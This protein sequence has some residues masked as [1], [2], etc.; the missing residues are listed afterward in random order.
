MRKKWENTFM[1]ELQQLQEKIIKFRDERDWAQFH[2]PKELAI[3]LA[4]ETAELMENF[5]WAKGATKEYQDAKRQDIAD[6]LA[7][8]MIYLL[9]F[10]HALDIN[11]SD[12]IIRKIERSAAKYPVEKSFG[13]DTKHTD[14]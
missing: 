12:A 2:T 8:C 5:Q 6:E 13:R 9:T 4:I 10:A 11:L 14:L 7:D 3:S 1:D